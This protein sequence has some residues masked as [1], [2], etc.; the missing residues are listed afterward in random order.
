M[1]GQ[2]VLLF[3]IALA[4]VGFVLSLLRSTDGMSRHPR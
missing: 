1:T 3:I 4:I 2:G